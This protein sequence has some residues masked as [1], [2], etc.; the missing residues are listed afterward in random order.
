MR[1]LEHFNGVYQ[2]Q[3]T[4]PSSL[5]LTTLRVPGPF[6]PASSCVY[7]R[8]LSFTGPVAP[9]NTPPA[10][11]R[12]LIYQRGHWAN[13]EPHPVLQGVSMGGYGKVMCIHAQTLQPASQ[14]TII[15]K[16]L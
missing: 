4:P 16:P 5:L 9:A 3:D 6:G 1:D 8:V 11:G 15:V 7:A 12:R 13:P 2:S 14:A 10:Q